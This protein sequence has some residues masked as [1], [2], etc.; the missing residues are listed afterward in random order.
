MFW[1]KNK[2]KKGNP[3]IPQVCNIKMGMRGYTFQVTDMFSL[4]YLLLYCTKCQLE[5][6]M[7]CIERKKNI[8]E[9]DTCG[10]LN[11]FDCLLY[12][13]VQKTNLCCV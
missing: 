7:N 1:S 5:R 4:M 9:I 12:N 3:C 2:K 8:V 11:V 10:V 6:L 13:I